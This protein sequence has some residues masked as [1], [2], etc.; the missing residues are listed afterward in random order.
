M[1]VVSIEMRRVIQESLS[2]AIIMLVDQ[3]GLDA[4]HA[5]FSRLFIPGQ[6]RYT[7]VAGI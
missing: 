7:L 3:V 4:F 6:W 1:A 5:L 2:I